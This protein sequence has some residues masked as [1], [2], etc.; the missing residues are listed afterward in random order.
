MP[1][2]EYYCPDCQLAF[3]T[4]RPMSE[5][6]KPTVCPECRGTRAQRTLSLFAAV[7]TGG[8]TSAAGEYSP[9]MSGGGGGCGCGSCGCGHVH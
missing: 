4:L 1:I 3:E 2:Y 8:S 9:A 7:S 5:S 6:D